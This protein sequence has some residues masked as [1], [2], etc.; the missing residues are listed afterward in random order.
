MTMHPTLLPVLAARVYAG[1]LDTVQCADWLAL[2]EALPDKSVDMCL[3]DIPYNTTACEFETEIDLVAW[4]KQMRR[5]MKPGGAVVMTG[6]QP[7]T[8]RLVMSNL[9]WFR[10]EWIWRK[11]RGSNPVN[12]HTQPMKEH[13]SVLV[14]NSQVGVY[15]PQMTRRSE[16]GK[17]RAAYPINP[18]NTGKRQYIGG[19]IDAETQILDPD[20]RLPGSVLD[21]NT[22]VGYHPTQ[23]PVALFEYLIR[24]Y[25]Q[26]GALVFDPFVG[27][28]TAALAA[29]ATGRRFIC[30]DL[31]P[32]YVTIARAR[33]AEPYTPDMF[34]ALDAPTEPPAVQPGLFDAA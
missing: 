17:S 12:A 16:S 25:T 28:G 2:C 1:L 9:K 3:S 31:S 29:R 14:F 34:A 30:G 11:N 10:Y 4:W 13:E 18:S 22:Q 26:P 21:F 23:K 24:T 5:V 8:S 7:F 15:N 20:N 19:F 6:S 33:L 27:S 32:E